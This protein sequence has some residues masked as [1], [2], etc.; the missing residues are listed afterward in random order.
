M[1]ESTGITQHD[2]Q[3]QRPAL[4]SLASL[5]VGGA[6]RLGCFT[7]VGE[8]DLPPSYATLLAHNDHMTVTLEAYHKSLVRVE[9]VAERSETLWYARQSL[10]ARHTDGAIVQYGIMRIDVAGLPGAVRNAIETHAAPL[11]RILIKNNLLRDVELLS[12]WRIE[13]TDVLAIPLG[14]ERGGVIYGRSAAIHLAGERAVDL[15]EIVTD[16]AVPNGSRQA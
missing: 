12:L 9:V 8:S 11:G 6:D 1:A 13:P 16:H 5:L 7:P 10:L 15:L 4:E 14:V 3:S 2:S